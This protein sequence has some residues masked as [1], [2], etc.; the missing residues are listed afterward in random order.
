MRAIF[1]RGE[2]VAIATRGGVHLSPR[3][4]DLPRGHPMLRFVAAMCMYSRD[5]DQAAVPGPYSNS[6]AELYA[7][8]V[9]IPDQEFDVAASCSDDQLAHRFGVPVEQIAAK[10]GDALTWSAAREGRGARSQSVGPMRSGSGGG[11]EE[12]GSINR[13]VL[14]GGLT[15]DPE[16]R[17]TP[18]GTPVT[19]LRLAF[20]TLRKIDG[21]WREQPNY[22]DVEVWGQRAEN[23][24]AYLSKGRQIAVDG[25]LEWTEYER[26]GGAKIQVHR[27]VADS[28]QY[29]GGDGSRAATTSG[30]QATHDAA[31][32]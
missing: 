11:N 12:M 1:Y 23:A 6:A 7:R 29:L 18:S 10:R 14:T 16:L 3:V 15:R 4:S 30:S 2:L 25:R 9:L 8:C 5:V 17:E 21:R 32:D 27:V 28:I 13:I 31:Q 22:V 19:T 20:T 26:A 24:A